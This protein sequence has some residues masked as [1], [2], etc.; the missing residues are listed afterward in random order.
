MKR[1]KPNTLKKLSSTTGIMDIKIK[2]GKDKIS[3]NLY[4]ELVVDENKINEELKTQPSYFGFLT[5]L[6]VKLERLRNDKKAE[7][8]KTYATL[9]IYYKDKLDPNTQRPYNNDVTESLVITNK[10]YKEALENFN[11]ADENYNLIKGCVDAFNQRSHL[12]QSLS[13]NVRTEKQNS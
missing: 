3:F 2:Y 8:G 10:K 1:R 4:E 11:K 5:L 9:F 7:L 6:M 13:A 12:I